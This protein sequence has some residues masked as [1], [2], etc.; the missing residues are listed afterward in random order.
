M[1]IHITLDIIFILFCVSVIHEQSEHR[2][3]DG[4]CKSY[5]ICLRY[6]FVEKPLLYFLIL[7]ALINLGVFVLNGDFI[8]TGLLDRFLL[9][10]VLCTFAY[11]VPKKLYINSK[12]ISYFNKFWNW[13]KI[14]RVDIYDNVVDILFCDYSRKLILLEQPTVEEKEELVRIMYQKNAMI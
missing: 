10:F 9:L 5:S 11:V 8:L 1:Y 12:G 13:D 14:Y 6:G 2:H 3:I 4:P 7:C